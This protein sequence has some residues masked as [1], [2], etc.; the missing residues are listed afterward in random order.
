MKFRQ[1]KAPSAF[2][3][4]ELLV[5][6]GI[7][8]ILS[9]L[10][11]PTLSKA[12]QKARQTQCLN[13]TRQLG[14]AMQLYVAEN[15]TAYPLTHSWS[16]NLAIFIRRNEEVSGKSLNNLWTC[17]SAKLTDDYSS[18]GYNAYGITI[19]DRLDSFGLGGQGGPSNTG[20]NGTLTLVIDKPAVKESEVL[21]PSE[22]M[23]IGDGFRGELGSGI[24]VNDGSLYLW[25]TD[26]LNASSVGAAVAGTK[27]S[28]T[29]HQAKANVVFCDGHVESPTLKFLFEDTSD[30]A[31]RRWNRD[32]QPH[33]ER[34]AP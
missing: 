34:L 7:I 14:L 9:A 21:S 20:T 31:L 10:M 23:A 13:N 30:E 4:M 32:H 17:P 18:Y 1:S 5:V 11:L 22:M 8:A 24:Y 6:I 26:I 2:T 29:R 12:M 27:R 19:Y 15:N 16:G 28:F 3:L 33:R 25:R